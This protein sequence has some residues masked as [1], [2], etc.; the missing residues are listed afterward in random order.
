MKNLIYKGFGMKNLESVS[1]E[2]KIDVENPSQPV[3]VLIKATD[4]KFLIEEEGDSVRIRS[5]SKVYKEDPDGHDYNFVFDCFGEYKD[6]KD[7]PFDEIFDDAKQNLVLTGKLF[8]T[9]DSAIVWIKE[10]V[11]RLRE[12]WKTRKGEY[13]KLILLLKELTIEN[14]LDEETEMEITLSQ[15]VKTKK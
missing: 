13:N 12:Y 7:F 8:S 9:I 14:F 3:V 5:F 11:R 10:D 2:I 1:Y 15:T 6:Y 4:Q